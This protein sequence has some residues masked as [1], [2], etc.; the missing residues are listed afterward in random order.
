[1]KKS[2]RCPKC[3][4]TR[5]GHI[6]RQPDRRGR[7]GQPAEDR[8]VGMVREVR[9]GRWGEPDIRE[10]WAGVLEAYVCTDCG[11]HESYVADPRTVKWDDI[12]GFSWVNPE[13]NS[14]GPYR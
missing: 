14:E 3:G 12:V 9:K 8:S 1:M 6:E 13:R 7:D 11:F 5:I 2:K 10:A 4:S